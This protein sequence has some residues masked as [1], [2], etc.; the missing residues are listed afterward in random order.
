MGNKSSPG[1]GRHGP[2][3]AEQGTLLI[4]TTPTD[5]ARPAIL[6]LKGEREE[7]RESRKELK[8]KIVF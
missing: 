1:A 6:K 7:R 8:K 3:P 5:A 2:S 4:K